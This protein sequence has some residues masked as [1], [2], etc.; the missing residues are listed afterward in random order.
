MS[1][2]KRTVEEYREQVTELRLGFLEFPSFVTIE[3]LSLCNAACEFCPYPTLERQGEKM[4][5]EIFE[6]I[7]NDLKDIPK[8][9][10]FSMHLS[11]VNEPFLD[12]RI[13]SFYSMINQELPQ[14]N[15]S[16]FTNASVLTEN[17]I[18]RIFEIKNVEFFVISFNDHRKTEYE[19]V[20]KIPY[21]RT[22]KHIDNLYQHKMKGDI[23]FPVFL[24]R[25]GDGTPADREFVQWC[26]RR[27]PEFIVSVYPRGDWMGMTKTQ[28]FETPDVGCRQW[29]QLH[30][31]ADGR[32]AFCC[33]DA[34]GKFGFGG[35]VKLKHALEIYNSPERLNIRRSVQS[36]KELAL[37]ESCTM[38]P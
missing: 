38:F 24:S 25:V 6:K 1:E 20:M 12:S 34:E 36:R 26:E 11:R 37:C 14:V 15:V 5:T 28:N 10:R 27:Y 30:F 22:I 33:I 3:T 7:I 4:P 21:E 18:E 13:F 29:F 31:L 9:H 17:K 16:F 19:R 23:K 2:Y 32:E 35:N 8:N